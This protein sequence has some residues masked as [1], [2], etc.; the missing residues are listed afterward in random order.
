MQDLIEEEQKEIEMVMQ[1]YEQLQRKDDSIEQ[2]QQQIKE[3]L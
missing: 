1:R 2:I 3:Y